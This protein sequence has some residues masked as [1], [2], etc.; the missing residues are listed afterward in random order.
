MRTMKAETE[1]VALLVDVVGS[2]SSQRSSLHSRLL[3]AADTTNERVPALDDLRVTVGDELQGVYPSLGDAIRA[4]HT[5]RNLL[6]PDADVWVGLGGGIVE[7]ID[8]DRGIQ[9]G[10]AWW[11]AR[12]SLDFVKQLAD[13]PG[14]ASARTAVRDDRAAATP[15]VDASLRLVDA[16][17][18]SLRDGSRRSLIGLLDGQDNATVAAAEGIS[19][20]A[21]SQR[22]NSGGLRPLADAIQAL[23][24]LS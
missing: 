15:C 22:V 14:H 23:H 17:L 7:V 1:C 9:D 13:E 12:E 6:H 11:N 8:A 3:A 21:N 2:R 5:F 16:H 18:A 20:S 10:S 24:T 4:S 19:P